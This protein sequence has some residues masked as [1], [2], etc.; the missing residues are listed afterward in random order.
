MG[1]DASEASTPIPSEWDDPL[2]RYTKN[3]VQPSGLPDTGWIRIDAVYILASYSTPPSPPLNLN[4]IWGVLGHYCYDDDGEC[5]FPEHSIAK[6]TCPVGE[7]EEESGSCIQGHFADL[8]L[9]EDWSDDNG[10]PLSGQPD[11]ARYEFYDYTTEEYLGEGYYY[12][13]LDWPEWAMHQS[14]TAQSRKV[15]INFDLIDMEFPPE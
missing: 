3:E 12:W 9:S 1:F 4:E 7:H 15:F 10:D 11:Y 14:R 8:N 13:D 5:T 2:Y 6:Y